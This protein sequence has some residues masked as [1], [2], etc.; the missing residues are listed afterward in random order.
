VAALVA[1]AGK[2]DSAR[3]REAAISLLVKARRTYPRDGRLPYHAGLL[4]MDKMFR[5][6]GLKQLRAAI[7]LDPGYR[8][9]QELIGAVIRAFNTTAQYDWAL[10]SFLRNDIGD[11][12]KPALEDV[13]K[14]HRNPIVRA[15]ATAELRRY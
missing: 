1:Q 10:A 12:A 8:T 3:R 15:R 9:D 7:K 13:A 5:S 14:H 6:D 4:Y 2:L 11:A